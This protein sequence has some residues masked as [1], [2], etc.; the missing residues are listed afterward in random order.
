MAAEQT[1][2]DERRWAALDALG[3]DPFAATAFE[4]LTRLAAEVLETPMALISLVDRKGGQ[5]KARVGFAGANDSD[6]SL[7]SLALRHPTEVMVVDD[8]TLDERVRGERFVTAAPYI[9]F[10]AA[11]PLTLTSGQVI[12]AL[13]VMDS[14]PRKISAAELERLKF[15]AD[16]VMETLEQR[17]RSAPS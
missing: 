3:L 11:A 9:R 6:G 8:A 4:D 14:K 13:C 1:E 2:S 17:Q 10:Y 12:G 16:Q 5:L 15:L 7:A